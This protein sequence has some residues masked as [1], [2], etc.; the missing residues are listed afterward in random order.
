[1]P[2]KELEQVVIEGDR[3]R[4][5]QV[6]TQLPVKDKKQLIEFLKRNLDIFTW[7]TYEA[8]GIDLEFIY[9]HLNVKLGATPKK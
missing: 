8:P 9:H 6:G 5:F 3:E 7:S 1:M 4:Y 2:C